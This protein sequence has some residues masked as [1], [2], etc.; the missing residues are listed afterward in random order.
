MCDALNILC[1]NFNVILYWV[2]TIVVNHGRAILGQLFALQL[3]V[4]WR[5]IEILILI[6]GI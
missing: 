1:C 5:A 6:E 4:R 2:I 3:D